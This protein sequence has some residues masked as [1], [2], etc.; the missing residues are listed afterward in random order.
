MEML[1]NYVIWLRILRMNIL[2]FWILSKNLKLWREELY[3]KVC[4]LYVRV[5]KRLKELCENWISQLLFSNLKK[6]CEVKWISQILFSRKVELS[7]E[8][9]SWAKFY[10][11]VGVHIIWKNY[12]SYCYHTEILTRKLEL[13]I[14]SL[15]KKH[16]KTTFLV[17]KCRK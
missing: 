11:K 13:W 6:S 4:N 2:T 17:K 7:I 1:R 12:V 15:V 9:F 10:G 8:I 3:M 5:P 16:H 14:F